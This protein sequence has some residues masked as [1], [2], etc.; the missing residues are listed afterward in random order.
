M[1]RDDR[2]D[3]W[4][5]DC[6][7]E[8]RAMG[9]KYDVSFETQLVGNRPHIQWTNG[10]LGVAIFSMALKDAITDDE[11]LGFEYRRDMFLKELSKW[12][13]KYSDSPVEGIFKVLHDRV[14]KD[15]RRG[16]HEF[17]FKVVTPDWV[18][19]EEL[20]AQQGKVDLL[21]RLD[22]MINHWTASAS[23]FELMISCKV[24]HVKRSIRDTWKEA[25]FVHVMPN[26]QADDDSLI[27]DDKRFE[28]Y[29]KGVIMP[30]LKKLFED[31]YKMTIVD[32]RMVPSVRNISLDSY[33]KA[34]PAV[35]RYIIHKNKLKKPDEFR[36][37]LH[38][39]VI[40]P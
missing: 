25:V 13:A 39:T 26:I 12:I 30:D 22:R 29:A 6:V 19:R 14:S 11:I 10:M 4:L 36:S 33:E 1:T 15:S 35:F 8:L 23:D 24:G 31:G 27:D 3:K 5:D 40:E 16:V 28:L 9:K 18:V 38:L 34:I 17:E 7:D 20:N 32:G 21:V 37:S 2:A